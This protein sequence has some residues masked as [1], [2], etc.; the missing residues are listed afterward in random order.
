MKDFKK[1]EHSNI[2]SLLLRDSDFKHK[3]KIIVDECLTFILASYKVCLA[4]TANMLIYL[5]MNPLFKE[6][7]I[8]EFRLKFSS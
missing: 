2:L 3:E 5:S 4:A 7:L 6:R 1:S 8:D